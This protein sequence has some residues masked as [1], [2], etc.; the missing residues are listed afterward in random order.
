MQ[1]CNLLEKHD[2]FLCK[3]INK[4]YQ[5]Y[6]KC[7]YTGK[8]VFVDIDIAVKEWEKTKIDEI[9]KNSPKVTVKNFLLETNVFQID[10]N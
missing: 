2:H 6:H 5:Y 4:K 8:H 7:F 9:V 10:Y 1:L 3:V